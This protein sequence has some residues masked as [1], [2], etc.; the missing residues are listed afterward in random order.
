[1]NN[2]TLIEKLEFI[3][4]GITT[5]GSSGA[6]G[7]RVSRAL[8]ARNPDAKPGEEGYIRPRKL[9]QRDYEAGHKNPIKAA[10]ARIRKKIASR[11]GKEASDKAMADLDKH[12]NVGGTAA[13][14]DLTRGIKKSMER[15]PTQADQDP[16]KAPGTD[17]PIKVSSS[18]MAG[19]TG[20]RRRGPSGG[21][22]QF[23][24]HKKLARKRGKTAARKSSEDFFA[25][26]ERGGTPLKGV[27]KTLAARSRARKAAAE[28][29]A[30]KHTA[31]QETGAK[32]TKAP[33]ATN[34][35]WKAMKDKDRES[36]RVK[37]ELMSSEEL[38]KYFDDL[39]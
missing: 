31:A 13:Q 23:G 30:K 24:R 2:K 14:E 4:E 8:S 26:V 38:Q 36:R 10:T 12:Q 27:R 19:D 28:A 25:G 6:T 5:G 3:L 9:S 34:K 22:V 29:R 32:T 18:D 37:R 15:D 21:I 35:A 39:Q 1:M 7:E 16:D 33:K 17:K 20:K 11:K